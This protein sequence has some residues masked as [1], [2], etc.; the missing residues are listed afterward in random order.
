MVLPLLLSKRKQKK[1]F[2]LPPCCITLYT[3]I[4]ELKSMTDVQTSGR[5]DT[6]TTYDCSVRIV[7]DLGKRR[8]AFAA[9]IVLW[10]LKQH[11]DGRE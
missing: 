11:I 8:A 7:M 1:V 4:T 6:V 3:N 5:N 10:N 2:A 9:V